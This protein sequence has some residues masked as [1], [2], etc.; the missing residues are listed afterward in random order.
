MTNCYLL[1]MKILDGGGDDDDDD[2]DLTF[3]IALYSP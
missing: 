3:E 1:K 2:D